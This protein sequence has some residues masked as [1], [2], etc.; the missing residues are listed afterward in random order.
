MAFDKH[1]N[2]SVLRQGGHVDLLALSP[3][4]YPALYA[5]LTVPDDGEA[6][7]PH[8]RYVAT[9]S[10]ERVVADG[11]SFCAAAHARTTGELLGLIDLRSVEPADD[12]GYVW[13]AART[14]CIGSGLMAEA[15]ILFIDE[16]FA[17]YELDEVHVV[18]SEDS[19]LVLAGTLRDVLQSEGVLKGHPFPKGPPQDVI[20][21]SVTRDQFV[22]HAA[23]NPLMRRIAGDG[24]FRVRGSRRT[25]PG[26]G[27]CAG[28]AGPA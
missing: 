26:R 23:S 9:A 13:A 15:V 5:V 6:R 12:H 18:L 10:W 7:R 16:A 11:M 1:D 24:G 25:S 8:G 19:R 21:A 28:R 27:G 22:K 2:G 17:R 3:D 14:A 20:Y 4:L